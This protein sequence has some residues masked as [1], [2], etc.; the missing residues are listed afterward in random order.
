MKV[1]ANIYRHSLRPFG[2]DG[3]PHLMFMIRFILKHVKLL[4]AGASRFLSLHLRVWM[5][6]IT[7]GGVGNCA[8]ETLESFFDILSVYL[9]PGYRPGNSDPSLGYIAR[10]SGVPSCGLYNP[11]SGLS[12]GL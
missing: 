8:F 5:Q 9:S 2:V 3:L 12:Y 4:F 1:H 7:S 6:S 10:N 11:D